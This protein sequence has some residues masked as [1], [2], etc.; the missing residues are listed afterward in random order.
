MNALKDRTFMQEIEQRCQNKLLTSHNEALAVQ[1]HYQ[2]IV[3][4][5]LTIIFTIGIW[6][7]IRA[8]CRWQKERTNK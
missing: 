2:S 1:R 6:I 4:L 3:I 5:L 7:A 8:F